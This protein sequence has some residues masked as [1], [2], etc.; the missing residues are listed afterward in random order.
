MREC[1]AK[2]PVSMGVGG[3]G[4]TAPSVEGKKGKKG[5][6]GEEGKGEGGQ[7]QS[8]CCGSTGEKVQT[9]RGEWGKEGGGLIGFEVLR[10]G[11]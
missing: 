11:G 2:F 3:P 6:E 4:R 10:W 8:P 1:K 5:G 7:I 9:P